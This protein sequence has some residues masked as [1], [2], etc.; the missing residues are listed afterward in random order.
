MQH[1][2]RKAQQG[3]L[4]WPPSFTILMLS[5]R[6]LLPRCCGLQYLGDIFRGQAGLVHE[7]RKESA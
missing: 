3:L 6:I 2:G 7:N 5:I 1:H 4:G